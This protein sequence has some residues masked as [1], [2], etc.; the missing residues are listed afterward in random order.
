MRKGLILYHMR[1]GKCLFSQHKG[2]ITEPQ[3]GVGLGTST[4][5]HDLVQSQGKK[6]WP[7][8]C[9]S[10]VF[11]SVL[12]LDFESHHTLALQCHTRAR[13]TPL[14]FQPGGVPVVNT[15][16]DNNLPSSQDSFDGRVPFGPRLRQILGTR[17]PARRVSCGAAMVACELRDALR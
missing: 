12:H 5:L 1:Q 7:P 14:H 13:G 15:Q 16:V 6:D 3:K 10:K 17:A 11:N 2:K 4:L 9:I 8:S